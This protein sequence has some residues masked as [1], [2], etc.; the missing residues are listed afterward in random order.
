MACHLLDRQ[1]DPVSFLGEGARFVFGGEA[2]LLRGQSPSIPAVN[3][4]VFSG[5]TTPFLGRWSLGIC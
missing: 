3:A 5:V 2:A 1:R 4:Q